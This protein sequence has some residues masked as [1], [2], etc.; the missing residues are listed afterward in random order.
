MRIRIQRDPILFSG[1]LTHA[2][3]RSLD[4][5]ARHTLPPDKTPAHQSTGRR[6]EQDACF[7]LR[8]LGYGI[9]ARNY[10]TPRPPGKIDLIGCSADALFH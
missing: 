5:L 2:V 3:I 8:R 1:R 7:H 4:W 6:G 10:R 9:V